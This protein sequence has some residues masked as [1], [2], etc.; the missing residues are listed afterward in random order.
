MVFAP[1]AQSAIDGGA[2]F[3]DG[4][5]IDKRGK[6]VGGEI[7]SQTGEQIIVQ[8]R[9]KE[10]IIAADSV[11]RKIAIVLIGDFAQIWNRKQKDRQRVGGGDIDALAL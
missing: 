10:M 5:M 6:L 7:R 8:L 1:Y 4:R 3:V 11:R 2:D 9:E